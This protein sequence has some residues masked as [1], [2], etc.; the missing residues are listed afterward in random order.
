M[1]QEELVCVE[2]YCGRLYI[3]SSACAG[4]VEEGAMSSVAE[5]LG[6][7]SGCK[8]REDGDLRI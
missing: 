8:W 6:V 3:G 2:A 5:V 1:G 4:R 7:V